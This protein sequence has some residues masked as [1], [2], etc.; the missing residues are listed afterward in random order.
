MVMWPTKKEVQEEIDD[1]KVEWTVDGVYTGTEF[2]LHRAT[3]MPEFRNYVNKNGTR[4]VAISNSANPYSNIKIGYQKTT[5]QGNTAI[6][7]KWGVYTRTG[8]AYVVALVAGGLASMLYNGNQGVWDYVP[9]YIQSLQ[10][11]VCPL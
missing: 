7:D 5:T 6:T 10:N 1:S 9:D 11:G 2:Y 4:M 8:Y 3:H